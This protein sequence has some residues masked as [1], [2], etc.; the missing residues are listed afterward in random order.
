MLLY[1]LKVPEIAFR[2]F[3]FG[4]WQLKLRRCGCYLH[5]GLVDNAGHWSAFQ[6]RQ[7][8]YV[9]GPI[10]WGHSGPLCHAL[11]LSLSSLSLSLAMSWTSM[12]RRRATVP[13][14]IS[15]EW[16]WG[17]SQWRMGPTF[18]KCFLYYN[19]KWID[20]R[21]VACWHNDPLRAQRVIMQYTL[22]NIALL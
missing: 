20:F 15:G 9:I 21:W 14:T 22:H 5:S 2:T 6:T 17:G 13:L 4:L 18:F 11:S 12:R 16:A 8:I 10:P 7:R 1:L 19:I 3:D